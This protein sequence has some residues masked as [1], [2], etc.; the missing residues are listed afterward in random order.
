MLSYTF[1]CSVVLDAVEVTG[2]V[3]CRCRLS[4]LLPFH[5]QEH[6]T[7]R[8]QQVSV[9]GVFADSSVDDALIRDA[10]VWH[11]FRAA[12]FPVLRVQIAERERSL[13]C[14]ST[15]DCQRHCTF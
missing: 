4:Y 1:I 2:F 8:M 14:L 15:M 12:W 10:S 11:R 7:L 13:F 9:G 5:C 3:E 6:Q